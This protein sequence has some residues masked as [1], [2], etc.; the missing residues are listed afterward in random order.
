NTAF[1][2]TYQEKMKNWHSH[3]QEEK[4]KTDNPLH[5]PQVIGEAPLPGKITYDQ[6]V[7]YSEYFIKEF[8]TNKKVEFPE[9][10]KTL[11]RL[12]R[13]KL[14]NPLYTLVR[15]MV[16]LPNGQG[17]HCTCDDYLSVSL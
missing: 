13:I 11:R 12:Y 7:K 8:F 2:S 9:I 5:G 15:N 3:V 14:N 6:A 4:E 1:L 17:S 10:G 16:L